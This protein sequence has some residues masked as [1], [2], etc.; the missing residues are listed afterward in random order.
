[1]ATSLCK[2]YLDF[3]PT[4]NPKWISSISTIDKQ[5]IPPVSEMISMILKYRKKYL[6]AYSAKKKNRVD[7]EFLL[8]YLCNDALDK[9]TGVQLAGVAEEIN[10]FI[11]ESDV[12]RKGRGVKRTALVDYGINRDSAEG[13]DIAKRLKSSIDAHSEENQIVE[14][15]AFPSI[16]QTEDLITSTYKSVQKPVKNVQEIKEDTNM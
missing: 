9:Q 12:V 13:N 7:R 8:K 10:N 15:R 14:L 16:G 1:M 6:S 4:E 5:R 11:D 2:K 3:E